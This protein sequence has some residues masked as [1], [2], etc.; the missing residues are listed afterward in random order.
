M[1]PKKKPSK[2]RKP[3]PSGFDLEEARK[4]LRDAAA[5][6]VKFLHAMAEGASD[7]SS[8]ARAPLQFQP[9]LALSQCIGPDSDTIEELARHLGSDL[10][11]LRW[12][13]GGRAQQ[14]NSPIVLELIRLVEQAGDPYAVAAADLQALVRKNSVALPTAQGK[15]LRKQVQRELHD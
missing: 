5:P 15:K 2:T 6:F 4:Q 8:R 12:D 3:K 13:G 10:E 9:N 11:E 14:L 1:P 7:Q